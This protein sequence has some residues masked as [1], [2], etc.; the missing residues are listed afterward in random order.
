MPSNAWRQD[1]I[2]SG[3]GSLYSSGKV[4]DLEI[5]VLVKEEVLRLEIAIAD[6]PEENAIL[7]I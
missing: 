5:V 4:C 2:G 1:G 7:W 3:C 6:K